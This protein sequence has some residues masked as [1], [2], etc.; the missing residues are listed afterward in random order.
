MDTPV[1]LS[2]SVL[3]YLGSAGQIVHQVTRFDLRLHGD[4][5]SATVSLSLFRAQV[6]H[7]HLITDS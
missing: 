2:V 1:V 6:R 4:T 3:S 7:P 5:A